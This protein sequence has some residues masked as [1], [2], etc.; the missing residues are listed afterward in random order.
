MSSKFEGQTAIVTGGASGIGFAIARGFAMQGARVCIADLSQEACDQ[1]ARAIGASAFGHSLDVRERRSI[2]TLVEAVATTTGGVDI[3]VNSAGVFGM[4]AFINIT[5]AEFDRIFSVN[6]RG[7][8]FVTQVVARHM[9]KQGRGGAIVNVASGA[10]RR[11]APGATVYSSSKA[12][13]ISITQ[14]AATELIPH[15]IR[16][17]A[18]APG[19]VH[20]PMWSHVE[21]EFSRV[22][23]VP[24][25]GAEAAQVAHT[26]AGRI[27]IP[28]DQVGAVLFLASPDSAYVV[29]QTLNVDGGLLMN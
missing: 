12:A 28:E 16:V 7:L 1:A 23:H 24:V 17:N 4:Q 27:A 21:Q 20:T 11:A 22:L 14:A 15:G 18:I 29:G 6:T 19:A 25:G 2:E 3:L 9:I 8:L 5:E 13:V 26:P 10:G